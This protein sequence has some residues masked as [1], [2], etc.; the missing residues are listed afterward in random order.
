MR[1]IGLLENEQLLTIP[2]TSSLII[3]SSGAGKTHLALKMAMADFRNGRNVVYIDTQHNLY[4]PFVHHFLGD[5]FSSVWPK[6]LDTCTLKCDPS[7]A[8]DFVPGP[9]SLPVT[10]QVKDLHFQDNF[11][12]VNLGWYD[13]P[14][15]EDPTRYFLVACLLQH[16]GSLSFPLSIYIDDFD[17]FGCTANHPIFQSLLADSSKIISIILHGW[18][19]GKRP[20]VDNLLTISN[21]FPLK[22]AFQQDLDSATITCQL[23]DKSIQPVDLMRLSQYKAVAKFHDDT[24]ARLHF[25]TEKITL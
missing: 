5:N 4:E 22:I 2:P 11:T 17:M 8:S 7:L 10:E 16:L 20:L 6:H 24:L 1:T 23:L 3:G 9:L 15:M 14:Y 21:A 13:I 12:L 25:P 19:W 18:Q